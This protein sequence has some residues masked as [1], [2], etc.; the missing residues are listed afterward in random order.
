MTVRNFAAEDFGALVRSCGNCST[1]Y[2]RTIVLEN[3]EVTAPADRLVGI[4]ENFGDSATFRNITI[5]GD[6]DRDITICQ[7]YEGTEG[8]GDPDETGS[9]PDGTHC[10]YSSSDI[11]YQ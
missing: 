8:G 3:V 6:D 9:D 10:R 5:I 11:T 7:K 4:N 1:Q 2:Q